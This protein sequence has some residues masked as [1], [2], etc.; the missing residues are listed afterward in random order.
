MCL[1][2]RKEGKKGKKGTAR[3]EKARERKRA[4]R[5]CGGEY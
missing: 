4:G 2:L 5:G 3:H 1:Y